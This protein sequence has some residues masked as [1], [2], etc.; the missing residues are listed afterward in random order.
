MRHSVKAI[1]AVL[2]LAVAATPESVKAKE[3]PI[4]EDEVQ[5]LIDKRRAN[6]DWR[7]AKL[8]RAVLRTL[9]GEEDGMTL[10]EVKEIAA[11]RRGKSGYRK[12]VRARK[13]IKQI[14]IAEA[15]TFVSQSDPSLMPMVNMDGEHSEYVRFSYCFEGSGCE[16][17]DGK[18]HPRDS[19]GHY[20]AWI[21]SPKERKPE[22]QTYYDTYVWGKSNPW[23]SYNADATVYVWADIP[24][25]ETIPTHDLTTSASFSGDAKGVAISMES[26]GG[27]NWS[28]E[29]GMFTADVALQWSSDT[30]RLTGQIDN[31]QGSLVSPEWSLSLTPFQLWSSSTENGNWDEMQGWAGNGTLVKSPGWTGDDTVHNAMHNVRPY[32]QF[33]VNGRKEA[34]GFV[35]QFHGDINYTRTSRTEVVGAFDAARE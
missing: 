35:G 23:G 12:W 7:M 2:I 15:L 24:A 26:A 19:Y 28:V 22:D 27:T 29:T 10:S 5:V 30:E 18:E 8:W 31:F 33:D 9:R 11:S 17:S 32:G 21:G 14:K 13:A 34:A 16:M 20:G 4:T 6:G 1:L 25:G 3:T